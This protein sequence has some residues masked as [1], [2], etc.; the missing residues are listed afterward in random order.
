MT[1]EPNHLPAPL[2]SAF[3]RILHPLVRVLIAR[4]VGF[5]ILSELLKRVYVDV[6]E[7]RFGIPRRRMTDS[8]VS[9]LTGLQRKDVRTLRSGSGDLAPD[10]GGS[11]GPIPRL[12]ARWTAGHPFSAD[13][14]P[15]ALKRSGEDGRSFDSL[16][17]SIS[18]DVHPRTLLDELL[19]QGL[20]QLDPE[21]DTVTLTE[22]AYLPRTDDA[23]MV[24]Y[25]GAN[26]GDHGEAAA[27][28]LLAAPDPGK[29]FERAVHYNR[30]S[31]ASLD[32]LD[33]LA[34]EMQAEA[35][36][37]LNRLALELQDRDEGQPEA[38]GRFRCGAYVFKTP[39][40]QEL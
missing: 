21:A 39:T 38:T 20:A 12:L 14:A 35:L 10:N 29:F 36:A 40:E 16:A 4:G 23:A 2:R 34:R 3:V 24:G 18:R 17:T 15:L 1:S 8:R 28:N 33:A 9:L 19:R 25:F 26:L 30:L 6:A 31:Q 5:S 27:A 32:E 22:T 37:A 7:R 11:A 13:G